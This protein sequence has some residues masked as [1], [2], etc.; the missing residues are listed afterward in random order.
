AWVV[1]PERE[2]AALKAGKIANQ[3][4][5]AAHAEERA[6]IA[7]DRGPP[8]LVGE[9]EVRQRLGRIG[10]HGGAEVVVAQHLAA[11]IVHSKDRHDSSRRAPRVTYPRYVSHVL[12]SGAP[13]AKHAEM[14]TR[15]SAQ[16]P[17]TPKPIG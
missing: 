8:L 11:Q 7:G 16:G 17:K 10:L 4:P 9:I 13:P 3:E 14:A 12:H 1:D 6:N 5:V 2:P 15:H